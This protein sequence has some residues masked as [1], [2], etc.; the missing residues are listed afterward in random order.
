[1]GGRRGVPQIVGILPQAGR[2][3]VWN[4]TGRFLNY[5]KRDV[6]IGLVVYE[7]IQFGYNKVKV[8]VDSVGR[9][10]RPPPAKR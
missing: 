6:S 7:L 1:M 4:P 2:K 3:G 5:F 9:P 8:S 10:R